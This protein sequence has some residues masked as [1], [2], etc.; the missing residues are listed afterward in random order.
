MNKTTR[1]ILGLLTLLVVITLISLTVSQGLFTDTERSS[2]SQFAVGTLE[3]DVSGESSSVAEPITITNLGASE[4]ESGSKTWYVLNKGS[5]PG[6]FSS[7][8]D[9]VISY[10][11]GCNDPETVVDASCGNP[12]AGE[13]ELASTV[14]FSVYLNNSTNPIIN[15]NLTQECLATFQQQWQDAVGSLELKTQER[16]PFTFAW[17]ITPPSEANVLQSDSITFDIVFSLRQSIAGS[18]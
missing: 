2:V 15:C 13:G 18:N 3:M 8:I 10:E 9:Q 5:L 16:I 11:N 7:N 6:I 4:N 12:G 1:M 17:N 14:N